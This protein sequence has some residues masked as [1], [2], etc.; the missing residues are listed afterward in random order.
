[1]WRQIVVKFPSY[2]TSRISAILEQP[3]ARRNDGR[4]QRLEEVSNRYPLRTGV[5]EMRTFH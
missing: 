4:T 5:G 1:M 3:F 2:D